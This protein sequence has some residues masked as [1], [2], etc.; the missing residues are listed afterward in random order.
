MM[1]D[2]LKLQH[3]ERVLRQ[4]RDRVDIIR[5]YPCH[6]GGG[7]HTAT[8][9]ARTRQGPIFHVRARATARS[10]PRMLP[11]AR[12]PPPDGKFGIDGDEHIGLELRNREVLGQE[13][14]IPTLR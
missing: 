14:R 9:S 13:N 7:R 2:F 6:G 4:G 3:T 8:R 11:E 12:H 10:S 5:S 1:T